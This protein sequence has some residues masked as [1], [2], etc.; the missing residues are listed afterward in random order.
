M[1]KV[2]SEIIF[3][4]IICTLLLVSVK[5]YKGDMEIIYQVS[6]KTLE[7]SK[8]VENIVV[9]TLGMNTVG[10][11]DVV[12]AIRYYCIYNPTV[13]ITVN[14][15]AGGGQTHTYIGENYNASS[16]NIPFNS[17]FI[18]SYTYNGK[19]IVQIFYTEQ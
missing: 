16:L 19:D 11:C 1:N 8:I 13:S 7:D 3:T 10:G 18:A 5:L 14:I 2:I 4:V 12:S 6:T 15:K 17:N 9:G